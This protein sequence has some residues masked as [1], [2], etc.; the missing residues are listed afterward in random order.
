M[1]GCYAQAVSTEIVIDKNEL[2]N[3]RWFSRDEA[4]SML[5]RKHPGRA[6]HPAAGRNRPPHH[7]QLG[8]ERRGRAG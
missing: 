1:I 8:R 2:E 5:A 6:D 7:P 3:A 4:A